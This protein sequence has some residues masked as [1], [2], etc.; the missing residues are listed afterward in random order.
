MHE[1]VT[2]DDAT[3]TLALI[4]GGDYEA[5]ERVDRFLLDL[6]GG[7]D[8]PV[9]FLPT[10]RP[11]I[12]MGERFTEYYQSLGARNVRVAPV[13]EPEDANNEKNARLL[14]DAGLIYIGWGSD[15]RI[16]QVITNTPVHTAIEEAYRDGAV[17]AG[18]SAGAR[19]AGELV[20]AP[21]N[22]PV[23]LR[24]GLDEGPPRASDGLP[25]D[26]KTVLQVWPGF[27][28]MPG[29]G[30][31]AHLAEWNRYGHLLLM[32]ALRPDLTWI[33]LDERTAL[34]VYPGGDAEVVGDSNV[35]VVRR[36]PSVQVRPPEP[37]KALQARGLRLDVLGHGSWTSLDEL[38]RSYD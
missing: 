37:G 5:S 12:R 9:V 4:G 22:G 7:P 8:T 29:F 27:N 13:Y 38:R 10:A 34:V 1:R 30:L 15:T 6:A 31:D 28:W 26:Q 24:G 19:V 36:S 2:A 32:G 18:T 35:I 33:G 23:G 17:L 11:S 25:L 21:A 20:I 14:R 16:Q 3:G